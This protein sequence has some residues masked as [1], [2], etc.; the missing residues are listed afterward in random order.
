MDLY[1]I[2]LIIALILFFISIRIQANATKKLETSKKEELIN[3]FSGG[4]VKNFL[5]L[6]ILLVIFYLNTKYLWI[7]LQIMNY[8]FVGA[9]L[10]FL[11][12]SSFINYRKLRK[13]NFGN[14]FINN[15]LIASGMRLLGFG[16]FF[17]AIFF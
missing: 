4:K 9:I 5:P 16:I 10:I 11:I 8:S 3:E 7:D 17:Y 15:F 6:L 12:F 2:F 1:F 13:R 14:S